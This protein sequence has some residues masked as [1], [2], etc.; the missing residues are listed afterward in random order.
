M[1]PNVFERVVLPTLRGPLLTANPLVVMINSGPM[2]GVPLHADKVHVREMLQRRFNF[3]GLVLSDFDDFFNMA[4][5]G[6]APSNRES[7]KMALNAGLDVHLT[8][9]MAEETMRT[10]LDLVSRGD[11]TEARIDE[12]VRRI[13]TL[14]NQLGLLDGVEGSVGRPDNIASQVWSPQSREVSKR[15]AEQSITLLLNRDRTLPLVRNID[16]LGPSRRVLVT[17]PTAASVASM[18]G[19]WLFN[20]YVADLRDFTIKIGSPDLTLFDAD[21]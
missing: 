1:S 3:S 18:C 14:K 2:N 12:S 11:I 16:S 5:R 10:I 20:W 8:E 21:L 13:L 4:R 7:V 9:D 15:I 19:G 17:G 6:Y